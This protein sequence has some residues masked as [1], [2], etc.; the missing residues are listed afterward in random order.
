[1]LTTAEEVELWYRAGTGDQ[2]AVEE[3]ERF[4]RDFV[5]DLGVQ[6][7][8][9]GCCVTSKTR[10]KSGP[11]VDSLTSGLF[12]AGGGCGYDNIKAFITNLLCLSSRA[13]KSC[14]EIGRIAAVLAVTGDWDSDIAR[15]VMRIKW[16]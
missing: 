12:V 15:D 13:A 11:S 4:I 8:S 16:K 5:M 2:E 3:L 1:M 9:G 10:D 6:G 7:V 14:D